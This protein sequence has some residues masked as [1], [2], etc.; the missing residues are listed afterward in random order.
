MVIIVI[1]ISLIMVFALRALIEPPAQIKDPYLKRDLASSMVGAILNTH[2]NC[3]PDTVFS[4]I[5][6]DCAKYPPDGS[7]NMICENN[8][9]SCEFAH[10]N[11]GFILNQTL[12]KWKYSYEF[13][14]VSP[15][16]QTVLRFRSIIEEETGSVTTF[17]Q[18]LTVDTSGYAT[19]KIVLCI[20]GT[21]PDT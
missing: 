12:D 20:G 18:P 4:K 1:I 6:I 5:L 10:T 13:K 7:S 17:S 16:E 9:R 3:T 21:C 19:M 15:S 8:M 2:S 14:V 11:I